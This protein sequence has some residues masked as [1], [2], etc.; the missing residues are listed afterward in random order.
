LWAGK[1]GLGIF[2]F[3]EYVMFDEQKKR[4]DWGR[5]KGEGNE[6][7]MREVRLLRRRGK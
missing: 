2:V 4:R 1:R 7:E 5:E 3:D 6:G